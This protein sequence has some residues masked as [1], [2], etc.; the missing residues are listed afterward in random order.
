MMNRT[1]WYSG[2]QFR[3]G[4]VLLP[5]CGFG[6]TQVDDVQTSV[7]SVPPSQTRASSAYGQRT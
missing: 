3:I 1:A 4:F 7:N 6:A 2:A 5:F